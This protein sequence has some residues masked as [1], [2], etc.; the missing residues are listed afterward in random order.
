MER[1]VKK[2]STRSVLL[3]GAAGALVGAASALA[4]SGGGSVSPMGDTLTT[5]YRETYGYCTGSIGRDAAIETDWWAF[6]SGSPVGKFSNLKVFS[7][8]SRSIGGAVKSG[9]NGLSQ[10]YSFWFRPTYGLTV[11]TK[12]FSFPASVL[13]DPSTVVEYEQ[14]LSGVDALGASDRSQLAFLIGNAWYISK[15]SVGQNSIAA[16]ETVSMKPSALSWGTAAAV[17]NLGPEI[18]VAFN[19]QLPAS[20]TV[21]AFGAFVTT[22]SGRVRFDNYTIKTANPPGGASQYPELT[23]A[24]SGCPATSPDRT[25]G[26]V[27][28]PTPGPDDGDGSPDDGTTNPGDG[29]GGGGVTPPTTNYV[30]CPLSEQGAGKA[31]EIPAASGAKVIKRIGQS[32]D[33]DRRDRALLSIMTGRRLRVGSFVNVLMGDYNPQSGTLA[34]KKRKA[35]AATVVRLRASARTAINSYLSQLELISSRAPLFP[36]ANGRSKQVT[37]TSAACLKELRAAV[38][39]RARGAKVPLSAPRAR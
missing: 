30:L 4:Q 12:E 27:V 29:S 25:G 24:V 7:Y 22:V 17:G 11:F 19:K 20:G 1:A 8:G 28:T 14:R 32:T 18:P 38:N 13:S 31:V 26:P 34:I 16:W 6:R 36:K 21:T 3:I 35:G 33:V 23:S 10:G 15:E 9:P 2:L 39:A 37:A 5:V